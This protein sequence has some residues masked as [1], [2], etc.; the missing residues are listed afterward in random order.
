MTNFEPC[1]SGPWSPFLLDYIGNTKI[2]QHVR[3]KADYWYWQ[4]AG[5]SLKGAKN[6]NKHSGPVLEAFNKNG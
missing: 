3:A 4:E 1:P 6:L 2:Y 5:M